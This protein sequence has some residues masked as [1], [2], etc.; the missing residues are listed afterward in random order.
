VLEDRARYRRRMA[1]GT[2]D[3]VAAALAQPGSLLREAERALRGVSSADAVIA[4]R[5]G[6]NV[7]SVYARDS[8]FSVDAP[9]A[10]VGIGCIAKLLTAILARRAFEAGLLAPD[11][12]AGDVLGRGAE[13]RA[14]CGVTVRQLLDHSHG[15]DDSLLE[16]PPREADSRI[17]SAALVRALHAVPPLAPPGALYSYGSAGAWLIA[18][19][20][21]RCT[22]RP[23]SVQVRDDILAPLGVR[24]CGSESPICPATGAEL[25]LDPTDLLRVVADVALERPNT[26]PGDRRPGVYGPVFPLPGWNPLERGVYLGWKYHGRGWFGHQSLWPGSSVFVRTHP[27]RALALVVASRRRSASVVAARVFGAHLPELFDVRLPAGPGTC[28]SCDDICV[29]DSAGWH[30]EIRA[31]ELYVQRR[32]GRAVRASLRHVGGGVSFTRPAVDS[33]PHVELLA[34]GPNVYLWNGRFVLRR[35][36]AAHSK[37]NAS[38]TFP[39]VPTNPAFPAVT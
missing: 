37:P 38:S 36:E 34:R 4:F 18:A 24:E 8:H 13:G 22:G 31:G 10:P 12:D 6:E 29:F 39:A 17:D 1:T 19:L 9:Y 3:V 5:C 11:Q 2:E 32:G 21:E 7:A 27:R 30:A 26:W 23:Y 14:L 35:N 20:L 16:S 28:P 33:F 15:F 25:A